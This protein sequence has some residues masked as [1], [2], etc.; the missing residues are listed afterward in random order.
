MKK[1]D[2]RVLYALWAGMFALTA[3]L[4]FLFPNVTHTAGRAAL[5][6]T[7][8]LFFL[9][10]WLILA[11]A[12]AAGARWH[13]RLVR[14]LSLTSIVMTVVLLCANLLS[15]GMGEA[16]GRALNAALTIVS[17]P[18]VCSNFFALPLFLWGTLV[19]GAISKN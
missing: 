16:M 4:G 12:K 7:A 3:V 8:A 10:P 17:A 2:Y 15:A 1:L 14:N 9:P 5:M 18:L 6:L 19:M 13:I 11:K